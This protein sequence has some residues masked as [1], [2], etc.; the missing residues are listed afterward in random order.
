[1]RK[2]ILVQDFLTKIDL[3]VDEISCKKVSIPLIKRSGEAM[4]PVISH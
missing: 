2:K 3:Y 1:V 4:V